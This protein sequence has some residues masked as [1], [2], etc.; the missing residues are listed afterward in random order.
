MRINTLEQCRRPA[1]AHATMGGDLRALV[2]LRARAT[3]RDHE[4]RSR[5]SQ[6]VDITRTTS[7]CGTGEHLRTA[8][9]LCEMR[10]RLAFLFLV[11]LALV[12]CES[13]G[14]SVTDASASYKNRRDYA[15]LATIHNHLIKGMP[16]AEVE[17]LLGEP[18]YSP[19]GGQDLLLLGSERSFTGFCRSTFGDPRTRCRLSRRQ[20]RRHGSASRLYSGTDR[21]LE[22]RV[23]AGARVTIEGGATPKGLAAQNASLVA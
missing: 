8:L 3:S 10:V 21:R 15:S 16:R 22:S 18:D 23:R 9:G 7:Q 1:L 13:A 20:R 19:T 17:R 2:V 12:G 5:Q 14:P 6:Q 4:R 11:L